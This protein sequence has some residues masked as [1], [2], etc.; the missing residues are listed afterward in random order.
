MHAPL[1]QRALVLP[2][3]VGPLSQ[4]ARRGREL[5]VGLDE[6]AQ[7]LRDPARAQG[8]LE[9]LGRVDV[10]EDEDEHDDEDEV[11]LVLAEDAAGVL[12]RLERQR[13]DRRREV[14]VLFAVCACASAMR[15]T[16]GKR[17]FHSEGGG[18]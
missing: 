18:G 5:D 14:H 3:P 13:E 10:E 17:S 4:E 15:A 1:P 7:L 16:R 6:H 8:Q 12:R 9:A 2:Q 11:E